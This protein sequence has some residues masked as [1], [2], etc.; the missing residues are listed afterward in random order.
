MKPSTSFMAA[1]AFALAAACPVASHAAG[2]VILTE[3]FNNIGTLVNWT[4][5]NHSMQ[6]GEP[7]FQ[8]NPGVFAAQSG[9]A[10]A[11]IAANYLS[12]LNG[13]GTI[14]NWL[15]TPEL[16]LIGLTELSF[17]T[18]S[19]GTAGFND[20]MEVR[21][22][23]GSGTA[24][25]GFTTL[26]A[27]IGGAAAYPASW[28]QYT[29]SLN[30][31]GG[32]RFAFRY[33]SNAETANYIGLDSV[34]VVAVPEPSAY[35]L[36]LLG[37]A[38][39][40]L[41]RGMRRRGAAAAL[42]AASLALPAAAGAAGQEGMIVVRDAQTGQLRAATPAEI[43]AL[44]DQ[45]LALNPSKAAPDLAVRRD[46][47]TL[48]KRLGESGMVFSVITRD[49][50]GKLVMQCAGS[51]HAAEAATTRVSPAAHRNEEHNHE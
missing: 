50:D 25:S 13:V 24:T 1:A 3:N 34:R 32:G 21:F 4:Q 27:T 39:L 40:T 33:T 48:R 37:L 18:R 45:G 23:N 31:S 47:G 46:D 11:Y 43:K 14:D 16:T 6:P 22:S 8:G 20:S 9:P 17:Y 29:A 30:L 42:L 51:E 38:G 10:D 44:H 41:L 5:T 2:T 26:L 28:Q 7:W 36:L 49:A 35:L 19:L 12:A 15:I